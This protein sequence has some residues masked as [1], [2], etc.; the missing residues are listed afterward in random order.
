MAVLDNILTGVVNQVTSLH[1]RYGTR[2]LAVET[3]KLPTA[4]EEIDVPLPVICVNMSDRQETAKCYCFDPAA[5]RALLKKVYYVDV[6][7]ISAGNHDFTGTGINIYAAWRENIL[8]AFRPPWGTPIIG[9]PQV[10]DL[11]VIPDVFL[12]RQKLN[13]NYDYQCIRLGVVSGE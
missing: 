10:F 13:Q 12:D 2:A 6:T 11:D 7:T 5:G 8:N 4:E 3:R 9:V 1:L